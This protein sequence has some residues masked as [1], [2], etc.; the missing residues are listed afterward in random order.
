MQF[1]A[2]TSQ[3]GVISSV[4]DFMQLEELSDMADIAL[5][6]NLNSK[7]FKMAIAKAFLGK[8]LNRV[9]RG[10]FFMCYED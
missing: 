6:T 10:V 4:L 5:A 9:D 1:L 2:S 8:Y 3:T 7:L